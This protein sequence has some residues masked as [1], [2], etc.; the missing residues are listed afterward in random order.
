ME[1]ARIDSDLDIMSLV[2]NHQASVW[3]YLRLLGCDPATAEDLTQETFL[4]VYYR[5][6]ELRSTASSAAYLRRVARNLF[7]K[8]RRGLARR[9]A[10]CDLD[11]ADAVFETRS[12][13]DEGEAYRESLRACLRDLSERSRTALDLRYGAKIERTEIARRLGMKDQGVKTLLQRAKQALRE[14][15][16]RRVER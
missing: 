2:K 10:Q 4:A 12:G 15:I 6:F 1:P 13:E 14:C 8:E 3:R 9:P 7:L 11:A 5:P 16:E